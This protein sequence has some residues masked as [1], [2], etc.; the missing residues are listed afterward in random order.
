MG[1]CLLLLSIYSLCL[2]PGRG[3]EE[4]VSGGEDRTVR[5]WK[6]KCDLLRGG[7]GGGGGG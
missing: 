4:F 2:F 1:T 3:G 7:G 5:V 6:G